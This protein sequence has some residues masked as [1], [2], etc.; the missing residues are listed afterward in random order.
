MSVFLYIVLD[1]KGKEKK[2]TLEAKDRATAAAILRSQ[3]Y[4]LVELREASV[5]EQ[6]VKISFLEKKPKPRELAIFCRQFLSILNAGVP[7]VKA[8]SML[9]LQTNNKML[10]A[11]ID[12]CRQEIEK[13]ASLATGMKKHREIFSEF[14]ITLVAAGETSGSLE[15]SLERMSIQLEKEAKVKDSIQKAATYPI[16]VCIV[17]VVV[18]AVMLTFVVP[19]FETLLTDLGSELPMITVAVMKVSDFLVQK[20]YIILLV[21]LFLVLFAFRFG[22]T[23]AGKHFFGQIA[24]S[25]P[26]FGTLTIK[27]A[28]ARMART[29]STLMSAGI[30]LIDALEIVAETMTNIHFQ[31]A[32]MQA[33]DEVAMGASL[34][35][36]IERSGVFPALVYQMIGVGEET[37]EI[38]KMLVK[39][40]E[41]YE[42][43]VE[44]TTTQVMTLLEPMII[45]VLALVVGV[46]I[47]AVL[48][49]MAEMYKAL[50][51]I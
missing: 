1:D 2:G 51:N 26:V 31:D 11:A 15:V 9:T 39:L 7:M 40:A 27:T 4:T 12:D 23:N 48:M 8:L 6:D 13:G 22:K 33:R 3:G 10:R 41:Y 14:F 36:C 28:S 29:L 19:Q 17:A 43:E 42:D 5:L 35:E 20:W 44:T 24:M 49:P 38:D 37:G 25:L 32:L 50:E 16:I 21:L 45:I 34:S 47:L 18:L 30:P 46:I